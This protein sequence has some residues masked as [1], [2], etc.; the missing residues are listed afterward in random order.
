M[1]RVGFVA[2]KHVVVSLT[3]PQ[4][5]SFSTAMFYILFVS[6]SMSMTMLMML[7]NSQKTLEAWNLKTHPAP[8]VLNV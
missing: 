4:V 7:A 3:A 5:F 6:F 1:K 2:S 8:G